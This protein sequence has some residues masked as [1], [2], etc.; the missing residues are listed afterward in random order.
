MMDTS[1]TIAS[2]GSSKSGILK[3][4]AAPPR[5]IVSPQLKSAPTRCPKI[6]I[7]NHEILNSK[8]NAAIAPKTVNMII[9]SPFPYPLINLTPLEIFILLFSHE[10][11]LMYSYIT[12]FILRKS[13]LIFN[14]IYS[15]TLFPTILCF[16]SPVTVFLSSSVTVSPARQ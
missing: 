14:L 9:F 11:F 13:Y 16:I 5:I 2:T 3:S 15:H 6:L 10:Y 7:T 12:M 1:P 4:K 8:T